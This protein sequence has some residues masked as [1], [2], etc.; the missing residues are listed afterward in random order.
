ML[1]I[2]RKILMGVLITD[3]NVKIHI[4]TAITQM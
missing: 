2:E 3:E 4:K 1:M